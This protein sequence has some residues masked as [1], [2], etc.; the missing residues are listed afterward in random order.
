MGGGRDGSKKVS[1]DLFGQTEMCRLRGLSAF[2]LFLP[3]CRSRLLPPLRSAEFSAFPC[4]LGGGGGFFS[5]Q[6]YGSPHGVLAALSWVRDPSLA[7]RRRGG[8]EGGRL[9]G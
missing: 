6:H 3:S 9:P 8:V 1:I 2:P 7:P 4:R 5:Q